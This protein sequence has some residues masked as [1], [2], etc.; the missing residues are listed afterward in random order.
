MWETYLP[1][2]KAI[3]ST[4]QVVRLYQIQNKVESLMR[5]G[6]M[7]VVPLLGTPNKEGVA[8]EQA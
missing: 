6:L 3:I 7:D 5:Y 8:N 1:K 4:R 2:F